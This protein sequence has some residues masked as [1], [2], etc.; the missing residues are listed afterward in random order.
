MEH[1]SW[2]SVNRTFGVDERV[3]LANANLSEAELAFA[4]LRNADLSGARM[5]LS[6]LEEAD[7]EDAYLADA[8]LVEANLRRSRLKGAALW[9]ADLSDSSLA[10]A[11]LFRSNL[12]DAILAGANLEEVDLGESRLWNANL[13]YA[14]LTRADLSTADLRGASLAEAS[15]SR[16]RL[17]GTQLDGAN[18]RGANMRGIV[19]NDATSLDRANLTD[20]HFS[21]GFDLLQLA[22]SEIVINGATY[23]RERVEMGDQILPW[24]T[25]NLRLILE[26]QRLPDDAVSKARRVVEVLREIGLQTGLWLDGDGSAKIEI[27]GSDTSIWLNVG[28]ASDVEVPSLARIDEAARAMIDIQEYFDQY[29]LLGLTPKLVQ[30]LSKLTADHEA[31]LDSAEVAE[32]RKKLRTRLQALADAVG[33]API[34]RAG[35]ELAVGA[36]GE[37]P[38]PFITKVLFEWYRLAGK[39]P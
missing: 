33:G 28:D 18:L 16:A 25:E 36:L 26:S 7:L 9:G 3:D 37:I 14:D 30:S 35:K 29:K 31:I 11:S 17:E 32:E 21:S 24:T 10:E 20:V 13:E 1:N 2:R 8:C 4:D 27:K 12:R 6:N 38:G 15:L 39:Q 23:Y 34:E 5:K 19:V 22:W